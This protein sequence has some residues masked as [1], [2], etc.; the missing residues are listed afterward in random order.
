M[1]FSTPLEEPDAATDPFELFAPWMDEARQL[2]RFAGAAALATA[3]ADGVPSLR[4][5]LVVIWGAS[6]FVFHSDHRSR[7][8][9]ELVANPNAALLFDWDELGRQVRVEGTVTQIS[10]KESDAYAATR[11]RDAL[12][13]EHASEQ[14][15]PIDSRAELLSR[16]RAAEASFDAGVVPRPTT[17]GGYRLRPLRVE[18]WQHREDRLHDRLLYEA[19]PLI[20]AD[21]PASWRRTRLQP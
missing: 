3:T 15:A 17:W 14:S 16:L 5:V 8:A 10:P 7:K 1:S 4:M 12:I 9:L 20:D 18:F 11:P 2:S 19:A 13:V 21:A 6:G